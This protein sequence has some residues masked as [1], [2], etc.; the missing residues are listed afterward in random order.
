[1]GK[2]Y[3]LNGTI[4]EWRSL[5]ISMLSSLKILESSNRH[6]TIIINFYI[7]ITYSTCWVTGVSVNDRSKIISWKCLYLCVFVSGNWHLNVGKA[8]ALNDTTFSFFL[9]SNLH[10]LNIGITIEQGSDGITKNVLF[11]LKRCFIN[12]SPWVYNSNSCVPKI[13]CILA[14]NFDKDYCV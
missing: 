14:D 4:A 2:I 1:M 6:S 7:L 11:F 3:C 8:G 12:V 13:F 10:Y 5:L 9:K